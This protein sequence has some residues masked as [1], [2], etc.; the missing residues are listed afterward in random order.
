MKEPQQEPL[1]RA[2]GVGIGAYVIHEGRVLLVQRGREPGRGQ[3]AIPGGRLQFGESLRQGAEREVFEET[4]VRI[5]AGDIVYSFAACFDASGNEVPCDGH[6]TNIKH[7][8]VV[9]DL[10]AEYVSGAVHAADDAL[11]AGW[12]TPDEAAGL[13]LQAAT[14][15]F[16][17][18]MRFL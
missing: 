5:A 1:R 9:I 14:R 16:L 3:W 11:D 12:F 17:N 4:G 6:N 18:A 15:R 2:P 8:Y 7:H 10:A 13:S